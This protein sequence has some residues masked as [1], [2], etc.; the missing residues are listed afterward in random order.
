MDAEFDCE[1]ESETLEAGAVE[2]GSE[3]LRA[4]KYKVLG[5]PSVPGDVEARQV[6]A[7]EFSGQGVEAVVPNAP[8]VE[9]RERAAQRAEKGRMSS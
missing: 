1:L 7:R 5:I 3:R 6:N 4:P 2:V 9:R 8:D